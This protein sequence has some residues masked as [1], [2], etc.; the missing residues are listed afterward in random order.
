[1]PRYKHLKSVAHNFS[2]SLTS[3]MNYVCDDYFMNYLLRQA[4]TTNT[5]RL[6]ID[7]LKNTYSPQKLLTEPIKKTIEG[8]NRWFPTLVETTGSSMNFVSSAF[9][10]IEFDLLTSRP[11]SCSNNVFENPFVCETIIID[12]RGKE[13]QYKEKGWWFA[14]SH[15]ITY[16]S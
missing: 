10:S 4:K 6:E 5:N 7:I 13:Y 11:C 15:I 3:L 14:D 12:N 1:M 2:Q 9:V 16:S 8:Y